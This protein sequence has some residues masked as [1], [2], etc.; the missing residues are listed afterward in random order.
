MHRLL[1]GSLLDLRE[2]GTTVNLLDVHVLCSKREMN[3]IE[4]EGKSQKESRR[5]ETEAEGSVEERSGGA[6]R[7]QDEEEKRRRE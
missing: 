3:E 4:I 5:C 7:R 2:E 6:A 1:L